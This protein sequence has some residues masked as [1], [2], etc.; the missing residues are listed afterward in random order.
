MVG[1]GVKERKISIL[2]GKQ[3]G[4]P[5]DFENPC[6]FLIF[7]R[8][9]RLNAGKRYN[10]NMLKPQPLGIFLLYIHSPIIFAHNQ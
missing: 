7:L 8:V 9:S 6:P 4:M 10:P 1:K 2:N 3:K 5:G